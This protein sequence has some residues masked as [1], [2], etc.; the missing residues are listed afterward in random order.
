[1]VNIKVNAMSHALIIQE[2]AITIK[3]QSV[4][5]LIVK[6]LRLGIALAIITGMY[7]KNYWNM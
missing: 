2:Y 3:L 4:G 5:S 6:M 7:H 1:M